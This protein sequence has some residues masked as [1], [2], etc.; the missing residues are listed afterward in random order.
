MSTGAVARSFPE[1]DRYR[2]LGKTG[3]VSDDTE[4]AALV[5]QSLAR[6]PDDVT[7]CVAAFRRSLLAWFLR[8]PWGIGLGTL[9][10]CLRI[11]L[12]FRESG[13]RS[14]GNGAAMRAAIIGAFFFD[15]ATRRREWGDALARVTHIDRRAVDGARYV[16]ELAAHAVMPGRER[17]L[18]GLVEAALE[19][20]SDPT[21]RT[22]VEH[23]R[24]LAKEGVGIEVAARELGT[25]GF[26]N[27]TLGIT[28][29]CFLRFGASSEVAVVSAIRA[30]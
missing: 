5:A 24:R 7:R 1:I 16:A 17:S 23:A 15:D 12:G 29:F 22:A 9:K 10:A 4:Q 26:V 25:T 21:V 28:T 6:H 2:L 30:G 18:D 20:V 3:Y 13:V 14:A 19:V 8:L 27:H 11:G